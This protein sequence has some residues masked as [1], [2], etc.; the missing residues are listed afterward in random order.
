MKLWVQNFIPK[1][2]NQKIFNNPKKQKL[3]SQYNYLIK[4]KKYEKK[5]L[6]LI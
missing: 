5:Y 3:Y 6:N 2:N 1:M 4:F